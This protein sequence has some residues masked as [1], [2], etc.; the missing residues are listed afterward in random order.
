MRPI[1]GLLLP[2]VHGN[3]IEKNIVLF[4]LEAERNLKGRKEVEDMEID[5]KSDG[6]NI[7]EGEWKQQRKQINRMKKRAY[8]KDESEN[9]PAALICIVC[10][11]V[12]NSKTDITEHIKTHEVIECTQCDEREKK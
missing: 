9:E 1:S 7:D 3:I 10:A 11:K 2:L 4:T 6:F 8:R 5:D 12:F